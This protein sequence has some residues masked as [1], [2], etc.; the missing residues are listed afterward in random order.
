MRPGHEAPEIH[1]TLGVSAWY[2]DSF[3]EAGARSP[4]DRLGV[5]LPG[6]RAF[7]LQ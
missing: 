1:D 4:G 5:G 2:Q 6:R 7:L 3:N